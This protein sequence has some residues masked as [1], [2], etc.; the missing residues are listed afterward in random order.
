M[1]TGLHNCLLDEKGR[2]AFPAPFR[3]LLKEKTGSDR[4]VLTASF[5]DAC[6]DAMTEEDFK[7]KSEK[8]MALPS[9]NRAVLA[10]KR[11]VIAHAVVVSFDKVGRV[12]IPKELRDYAGL[13]REAVWAGVVDKVELWSRSKFEDLQRQRLQEPELLQEYQSYFESVGL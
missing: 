7:E 11:V 5:N 8:I 13:E 3:A 4:F 1:F 10:F 6:L 9:S 12:N 2:I